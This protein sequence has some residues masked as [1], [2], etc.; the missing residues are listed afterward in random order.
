MLSHYIPLFKVT[1]KGSMKI[2]SC[3]NVICVRNL[4]Q[5]IECVHEK[6]KQH[7]C[8]ICQ[9]SFGWKESEK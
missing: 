8:N 2:K 3:F 6:L 1:F 7:Q 9:E 4:R 5:H